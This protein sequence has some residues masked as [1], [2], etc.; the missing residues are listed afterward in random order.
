MHTFIIGLA[1]YC[2]VG[3]LLV[4]GLGLVRAYNRR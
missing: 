4:L 1:I 2:G 3:S